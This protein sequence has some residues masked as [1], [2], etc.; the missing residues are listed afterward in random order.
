MKEYPMKTHTSPLSWKR[1]LLDG[2]AMNGALGTLIYSSMAINPEIWLQAAPP[3]IQ[4]A[5]GPKSRK[6]QIQTVVLAVPFWVI[7]FGGVVW[8][9]RKLRRDNRGSL[10]FRE[11]F[12]H[13]YALLLFYWLF[14]LAIIDWLIFVTFTPQFAVLP[15][16]ED[17]AGHSDY[18]FHLTKSLPALLYFAI[19]A[20]IIAFFMSNRPT[21]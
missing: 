20:L 11:A 1:I 17:M 21:T 16:T 13:S 12:Y 18:G 14:D 6:T 5:V 7:L 8:S 3:D 4:E 2:S 9:N 10:T 19:P 15:G